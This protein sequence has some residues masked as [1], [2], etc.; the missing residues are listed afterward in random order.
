M[1]KSLISCIALLAILLVS[2]NTFAQSTNDIDSRLSSKFSKKEL[3]NLDQSE[4]D[5]WTFYLENSF[6]IVDIPKEKPD[7][8]PATIS[9]KSLD[10]KDINVFKLG[11]T[12][13]EFARDYFRI[14]GTNKMIIVLP[15]TEIDANFKKQTK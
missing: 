5:Y 14:E 4:L 8:V 12:P 6:E 11:L 1:I 10:K 9:L 7:A 2:S 3:K 13:H 15:Q